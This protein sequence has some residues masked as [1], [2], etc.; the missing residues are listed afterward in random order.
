MTKHL[1]ATALVAILTLAVAAPSLPA[2]ADDGTGTKVVT[3]KKKH[4]RHVARHVVVRP[5]SAYPGLEPYRSF[6]FRG[7]FPGSCAYDRAAGNCMIDLG[8][9]RCVPCDQG[10]GGRF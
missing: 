4:K 8:Y 1:W 3:V 6:G 2:K 7:E 5:R 10:G 9:G